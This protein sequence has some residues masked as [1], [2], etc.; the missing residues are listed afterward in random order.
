MTQIH[1]EKLTRGISFV[2]SDNFGA[3]RRNI[4]S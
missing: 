2:T 1:G 4:S 3:S